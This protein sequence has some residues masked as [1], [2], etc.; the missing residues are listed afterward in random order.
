MG[1]RPFCPKHTLVWVKVIPNLASF[2]T[3]LTSSFDSLFF[4]EAT[5]LGQL[6]SPVP[7][8]AHI[9]ISVGILH[10]RHVSNDIVWAQWRMLLLGSLD[11]S[12]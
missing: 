9:E 4:G 10:G 3:G 8:S 2:L 11:S 6:I 12:C 1:S 7:M 5:L